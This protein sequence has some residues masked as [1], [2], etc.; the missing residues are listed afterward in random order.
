MCH[1]IQT[2]VSSLQPETLE[3]QLLVQASH[4][5]VL[6]VFV[7]GSSRSLAIG[8][9]FA[10]GHETLSS[11]FQPIACA[12]CRAFL[13]LWACPDYDYSILYHIYYPIHVVTILYDIR[14]YYGGLRPPKIFG[15]PFVRGGGFGF[16][17][18]P[19]F[20]QGFGHWSF[21]SGDFSGSGSWDREDGR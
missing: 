20:H 11:T 16:P 17:A 6:I 3:H 12:C 7:G 4:K 21:G 1:N 5:R 8:D 15:G 2:G 10:T 19:W 14:L 13:W 18:H 9:D